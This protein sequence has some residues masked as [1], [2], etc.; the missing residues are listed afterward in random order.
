M[1]MKTMRCQFTLNKVTRIR[2]LDRAKCWPRC[3]YI[4][5]NMYH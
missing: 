4:E 2:K 1:Q 5:A 3:R